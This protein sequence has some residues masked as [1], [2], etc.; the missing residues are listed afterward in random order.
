MRSEPGRAWRLTELA[1][2]AA[3]SRTTFALRFKQAAGVVPLTYLT[4]WRMRLAERA[5]RKRDTLVATLAQSLGYTSESA[6]SIAFKCAN[7]RSP[8]HYRRSTRAQQ[9]AL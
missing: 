9:N 3:M 5:L 2:A 6:F 1:Q 7:G 8:T 4:A